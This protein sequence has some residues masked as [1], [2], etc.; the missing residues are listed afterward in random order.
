[1]T[2][3][4][5]KVQVTG[6]IG[7]LALTGVGSAGIGDQVGDALANILAWIIAVKC[8]CAPPAD[9]IHG[10]HTICVVFVVGL[11]FIVHYTI[12]KKFNA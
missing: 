4:Q 12:L 3:V 8:Q 1:M 9:V 5:P 10:F 2:D 11:A 7:A 6:G